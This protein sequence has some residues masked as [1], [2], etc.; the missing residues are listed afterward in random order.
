VLATALLPR[1][2]AAQRWYDDYERGIR[3][4]EQGDAK[5]A[6]EQ[7]ERAIRKRPEPG[8][9]VL[10]YGTNRLASYQPYLKLAEAHL[11]LGDE[12]AAAGAL[13]RARVAER[14]P[15]TARRL[16]MRRVEAFRERRR[17]ALATPTPAVDPT[18]TPARE[19]VARPTAVPVATP[20]PPPAP[21]VTRAGSGAAAGADPGQSAT[22]TPRE[23][24]ASATPVPT[25][26]L[27]LR[28]TPEDVTVLVGERVLG[29]TPLEVELDAGLHDVTLRQAGEA[30][31]TF[32]VRV[33]ADRVTTVER[34]LQP[35][36]SKGAAAARAGLII[37]SVPGGAEVYLDDVRQ[38][39]TDPEEGRLVLADVSDGAHRLR[40]SRTGYAEAVRSLDLPSGGPTV[41][42]VTLAPR[43]RW[44]G[45]TVAAAL[46]ALAVVAGMA[47]AR[48]RA[49]PRPD[50]LE[51]RRL[52]S[53]SGAGAGAAG[54]DR[55]PGETRG[56]TRGGAVSGSRTTL[57]GEA[58]T[59]ARDD[60]GA[61]RALGRETG[62][63]D[64]FG[65]YALLEPLGKGG[66]ASVFKAQR[67]SDV[68][69]LKRPLSSFVDDAEFR[70]R[71]L[72]EAEI[73]R[74]LHHPNIIR[75]HER[76]EVGDVPYFTMELVEGETLQAWL[77][78][79]GPAAPRLAS[80]LV[81]QV[82]EALDY[83]HLKGVVH[84]DL[85]PSNIML[86]ESG[87][88]KVM[89]Y[90]IARAQRMEGLTATGAFLGTP[91]YV[92]P[93]TV[94]GLTVDARS[95][96]YSLGVIFYELLTGQRPFVGA[97]PFMTLRMHCSDPPTP[98]S[99]VTPGCPRELESLVL[100]L[101]AKTPEQRPES[102][103]ALLIEL[104]DY[105]N[106]TG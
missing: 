43:S 24:R 64:W 58:P 4:L 94:E 97:T 95:D 35:G 21:G 37:Y 1:P 30:D 93:E 29:T 26:S 53:P 66:M 100:R 57:D 101:L 44:S 61:T 9:R 38:G 82:A 45:R 47:L 83:A 3:A 63:G 77:A 74:T 51:T 14:E 104:R 105:L 96:L 27:R 92:A 22:P 70:Q 81:S 28:T 103:E 33:A 31:R 5:E 99:V 68:V 2:A 75:I 106:R 90:G 13:E 55:R 36:A 39:A 60:P 42:R 54:R 48:R 56:E 46:V 76:G 19:P 50:E 79:E 18:P 102:A 49:A 98:P 23:A 20:A 88:V 67:G 65:D 41:V 84:R 10:T 12:E 32:P 71:F 11:L 40:L 17:R 69:A 80:S 8:E 6:I 78:R 15:S 86:L 85:K 87:V 52:E 89:D 73:G 62:A 16:L 72:R 59:V 91:E 25:G 34:Y 7:L